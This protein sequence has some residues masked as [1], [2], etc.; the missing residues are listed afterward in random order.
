MLNI[1]YFL[2]S[3]VRSWKNHLTIQLSSLLVLSSALTIVFSFYLVFTN[4]E[5]LVVS[6]GSD[7]EMNVYLE[8]SIEPSRQASLL[9]SLEE[10]DKFKEIRYLDRKTTTDG[11]FKKM[12]KY[13]PEFKEDNE[14]LNMVPS[15]YVVKML[16]AIKV[17]DLSTLAT[18]I[19]RLDGVDDVSYGQEWITNFSVFVSA[20]HKTGWTI[21]FILL[22]GSLF[23]IGYSIKAIVIQRKEEVEILELVGA[24]ANMIRAPYIFEGGILGLI[25]SLIAVVASYVLYQLQDRLLLSEIGLWGLAG[26]FRFYQWYEVMLLIV[27]GSLLGA[28][29]AYLCVKKINS[30]WAVLNEK[31]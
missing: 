9:K 22:F 21:I 13:V 25:S 14:F 18:N 16:P 28:G 17:E 3:V 7:L 31:A 30:G 26:I 6:W 12:S 19:M 5:R 4:L 20:I 2:K 29:T 23:V 8:D 11:F 27:V 10:M 24:T 15:S 1:D